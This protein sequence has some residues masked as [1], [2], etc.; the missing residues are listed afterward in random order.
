MSELI[1]YDTMCRAIAEAHAVNEV[2]DVRDKAAAL[3]MIAK[4][5]AARRQFAE[6]VVRAERRCGELIRQGQAEGTIATAQGG[7]HQVEVS[8]KTTL[9]DLGITR[10]QS[11]R[12]QRLADVSE[13]AFEHALASTETPPTTNG[14]LRAAH[15][16]RAQGTGENEWYTPLEYIEA[17]REV[18]GN[19]DLDPAS[20]DQAQKDIGA[21]TYFTRDDDGLAQAWQGRVYLNP[22][23][24][25]PAIR[26]FIEKLVAEHQAGR[27]PEA[28]ALT[29]NY[30]DTVWFHCAAQACAAICFTRGRIAFINQD[31]EKA[32]PTQ[33][34]A[35]FYFGPRV[36]AFSQ[37]FAQYGFVMV[38]HG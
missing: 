23:Y 30:T 35:F 7:G 8:S 21:T 36:E 33:G 25:Q 38:R 6:V 31:G 22:P 2:K 4:T 1:R 13:D 16:H 28:I 29:H 11:S 32:A 9:E 37:L 12:F 3:K 26:L 14:V 24:S 15:N 19:I 34:Q 10:D 20:S 27:V 5:N 18:L 17:A